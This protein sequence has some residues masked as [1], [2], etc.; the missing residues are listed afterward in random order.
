MPLGHLYSLGGGGLHEAVGGQLT[1]MAAL[2]FP[3]D[4]E[5]LHLTSSR[6]PVGCGC[7]CGGSWDA[8]E[9]AGAALADGAVCSGLAELVGAGGLFVGGSSWPQATNIGIAATVTKD[10]ANTLR[11]T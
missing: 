4:I 9:A 2:H 3:L 7:G 5:T 10:F 11:G 6:R 1:T 8:T